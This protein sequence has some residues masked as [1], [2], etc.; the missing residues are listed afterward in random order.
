MVHITRD[1]RKQEGFSIMVN[2]RKSAE[3][4]EASTKDVTLAIYAYDKAKHTNSKGMTSQWMDAQVLQTEGAN[5]KL[6][7]QTNPHLYLGR[8]SE[9]GRRDTS[10]PY[11]E[12][13][14]EAI[15]EAAGDN[16]QPLTDKDGNQ[17]GSIYLVQGDIMF[18][19]AK[20]AGA[21]GAE[22]NDRAAIVNTSEGK[23]SPVP[24]DVPI[25]DN[26]QEAQFE[27]VRG[28][29]EAAK[30]ARAAKAA[31]SK[32]APETAKEAPAAEVQAAEVAND[33]PEF[34]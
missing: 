28:H 27:A 18:V 8:P 12:K 14:V 22:A 33:E 34:G 5:T 11:R 3:H 9:G 25:P 2:I 32:E 19:N 7:P 17:V 26:V 21:K 29:N 1:T 13:Q 15:R 6:A 20:S 24:E 31:Q 23:L 16:V 4:P 10:L 30:A